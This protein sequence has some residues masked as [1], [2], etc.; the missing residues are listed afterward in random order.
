M[1]NELIEV[2]TAAVVVVLALAVEHYIPWQRLLGRRLHRVARYVLGCLAINVPVSAVLAI[3]GEWGAMALLW[4]CTISGGAT[5]GLLYL[6]D[7][8][9]EIRSRAEA[10]RRENQVLREELI[11]GEDEG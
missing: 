11:Y 8:W 10:A 6:V 1:Q 7:A 5:V 2:G 4:V 3:W 9:L